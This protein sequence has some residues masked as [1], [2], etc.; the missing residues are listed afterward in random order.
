MFGLS[1]QL[2]LLMIVWA[3]LL[4]GVIRSKSSYAANLKP[5]MVS[6]LGVILIFGGVIFQPWLKLSFLSYWTKIPEVFEKYLPIKLVSGLS[7]VLGA[8]W[9][10]RP[11]ELFEK[12]TNIKG[13]LVALIPSYST[14]VHLVILFPLVISII[15]FI[16]LP[17]APLFF[18]K[19]FGKYLGGIVIFLSFIE[20]IFLI[21]SIPELDAVGVSESLQWSLFSTLLG[22]RLG[23][24]PWFVVVGLLLLVFGGLV[25]IKASPPA[26]ALEESWDFE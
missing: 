15:S 22:V 14:W 23:N 2:L 10:G 16:W 24:G 26:P 13:W 17:F 8:G 12:F 7:S 21:I 5:R 19:P 4:L 18:G 9:F 25:E 20:I 11:L 6:L 1:I 3:L